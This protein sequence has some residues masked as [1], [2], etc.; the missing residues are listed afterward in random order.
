MR[1]TMTINGEQVEGSTAF[2]V[3]NPATGEVCGTAPAAS[4]HQVRQAIDA[5]R[6]AQP[7]WAALGHTRRCELLLQ[8]ADL[9]EAES[10]RLAAL[11]TTEQGKPLSGPGSLFEMEAAAGFTRV[12]ATLPMEPEVVFADETRRDELHY[13][14]LGVVAAIAP[15]NWP[16]MIAIW[17]IMP[18][19]RM[20]NTVVLK[21]S[22]LTPLATL[23]L[24][25]LIDSVLPDGVLN[26]I[27]G[28]GQVGAELTADP[29]IDKIMFTGSVETGRKVAGAAADSLAR[30]TLELGGNDISPGC[31][32]RLGLHEG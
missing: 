4:A 7:A 8:V 10:G 17:Q 18:A 16:V 24:V 5:A 11:I 27:S 20:G 21:P 30:L 31:W 12:P 19:L 23:E 15:W 28:D 13:A 26:A 2:D 22:E 3:I 25:R 9:I 29:G 6:A 32:Q 14:P 1:V